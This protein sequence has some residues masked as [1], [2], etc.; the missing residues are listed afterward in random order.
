MLLSMELA[1][2][3]VPGFGARGAGEVPQVVRGKIKGV[4][5]VP[6]KAK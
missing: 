2:G 5:G 6:A 4:E 1:T 3:V